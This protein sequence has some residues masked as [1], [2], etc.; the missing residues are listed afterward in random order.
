MGGHTTGGDR[1]GLRTGAA[2]IIT[3]YYD[4]SICMNAG[5]WPALTTTRTGGVIWRR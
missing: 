4:A 3:V 1:H 5:T 2:I